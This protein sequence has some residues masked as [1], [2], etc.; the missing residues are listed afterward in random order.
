[1]NGIASAAASETMPRTPVKA[2]AVGHCQGG[3]GS[4]RLDRR[5][6]PTREIGRGIHPDEAR[7]D[8]H[9]AHYR[10]GDRQVED[11][12]TADADNQLSSS[13]RPVMRNTMPSIR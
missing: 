7:D 8:Y 13:C 6:K 5:N 10:G 3:E 4:L 1:M 12:V 9:G 11:R 2:S